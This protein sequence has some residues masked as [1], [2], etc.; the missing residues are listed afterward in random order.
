ML[1]FEAIFWTCVLLCAYPYALFPGLLV[2]LRA[3]RPGE[4]LASAHHRLPHVTMI[5]AA[6]DEQDVIR[7]KLK[8]CLAQQYPRERLEILVV[9]DGS[10][11]DTCRRVRPFLKHGVRFLHQPERAGKNHAV[12]RA[13]AAA[14]GEVLVFSDANAMFNRRAVW[15]LVQPFQ[16]ERVALVAGEKRV[17]GSWREAAAVD[18]L[19]W[20]LESWLKAQ[21]SRH[22]AVMGA[23]GEILAV[24]RSRFIPPPADSIIEDYILTM[25]QL[26]DGFRVV[27]EPRAVATELPSGSLR[28]EFARKTRIAAGGW[29]AVFRSAGLL[30]PRF[31]LV[32]WFFFSHRVMRW[33]V[34]PGP[35]L[36]LLPLNLILLEQ[37]PYRAI[38]GLQLALWGVAAFGFWR[39]TTGRAAG[40]AAAPA[41]FVMAQLAMLAG[42]WRYLTRRQSAVW[43]RVQRAS[44]R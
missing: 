21:E 25:R 17:V 18:G 43:T 38:F 12:S 19:Y 7:A 27:Y 10:R 28:D 11:D 9:T 13:V 42:A 15:H 20:R 33:L 2:L 22:G 4:S 1:S 23:A 39:E 35:F 6:C 8:N 44:S 26:L 41:F 31:G 40:W 5:V 30:A 29:Q 36:A 16:D 34:V 24:R 32:C 14:R 37:M 3:V